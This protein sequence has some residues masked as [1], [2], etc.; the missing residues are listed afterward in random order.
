M[1][2]TLALLL[3]LAMVFSMVLPVGAFGFETVETV[4]EELPA[5]VQS[6]P[7]ASALAATVIPGSNLFTGTKALLTFDDASEADIFSPKEGLFTKSIVEKP[8]SL[9]DENVTLDSDGKY[10]KMLQF[11]RVANPGKHWAGYTIAQSFDGTRNYWITWDEYWDMKDL[12]TL[13]AVF[14]G[15]NDGS[16]Q[17]LALHEANNTWRHFSR[18]YT[19]KCGNIDLQSKS[20]NVEL[21]K[22]QSNPTVPLNW[23]LDNYGFYPYYKIT[24]IYPDGTTAIDQVLFADGAEKTPENILTEYAPKTDNFPAEFT[25]AGVNYK[26]IGWSTKSGSDTVMDTIA[27]NGEDLTLYPVYEKT[28]F[29]DYENFVIV[30][31][32]NAAKPA[33]T[34]TTITAKEAVSWAY[35][36][37]TT[38]AAVTTTETTAVITANGKAGTVR[39]TA[40]LASD[41]SISYEVEV[42]IIGS[43][44]WK[45]GLNVLTGSEKALDFEN[46]S[47][48][49]YKYVLTTAAKSVKIRPRPASI[50]R[51]TRCMLPP[52]PLV[53]R[54]VCTSIRWRSNDRSIFPMTISA[55]SAH[56]GLWQTVPAAAIMFSGM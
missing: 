24:Y 50:P 4:T 42:D 15:F 12:S 17:D 29:L 2:K 25:S 33:P 56:I 14:I 54:S 44:E 38:E 49:V 40:T 45:P 35:D 21:V 26:P 20:S 23:Y 8:K 9:V 18:V 6:E 41:P 47:A 31:V 1:K 5:A 28:A 22:D 37:G 30:A 39:L 3:T 13:W 46:A 27:L 48:S 11:H 36:L 43:K 55:N 7:E 32:E 53:W 51:T 10:G 52:I 16:H 19:P 34:S